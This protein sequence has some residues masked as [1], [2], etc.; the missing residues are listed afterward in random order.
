M[1]VQIWN[2]TI[3]K[4][5]DVPEGDVAAYLAY[6]EYEPMPAAVGETGDAPA[7]PT[8]EEVLAKLIAEA[9]GT[10]A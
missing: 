2:K 9:E 10:K 8:A 4:A 6:P 3:G 7:E 5:V 1:S